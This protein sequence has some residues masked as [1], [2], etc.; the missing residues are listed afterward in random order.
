M[1]QEL[2]DIL[3]NSRAACIWWNSSP[4][5]KSQA[6]LTPLNRL[7]SSSGKQAEFSA[8]L[9][10]IVV[11]NHTEMQELEG[12]TSSVSCGMARVTD[13]NGIWFYL[14]SDLHSCLRRDKGPRVQRLLSACVQDIHSHN[15]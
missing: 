13:L 12:R 11:S 2:G 4:A 14:K 6:F 8:F 10:L 3:L 9:M 1:I 5:Q 7:N 15:R